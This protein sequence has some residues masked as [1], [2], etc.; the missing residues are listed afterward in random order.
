MIP[1][2]PKTDIDSYFDQ[3]KPPIKT[4]IKNQLK[5]MR[6]ANIIMTLWAIPKKLMEQ[7]L[8]DL[9]DLEDDTLYRD[10]GTGDNYIRME[11]PFNSLMTEFFLG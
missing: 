5:E 9:K 8:I 10:D 7:P 11:I 4:L 1:D 2:T 3:G 6:S